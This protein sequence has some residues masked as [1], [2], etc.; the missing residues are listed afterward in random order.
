LKKDLIFS[1]FLCA[2]RFL[3]KKKRIY[4]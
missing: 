4:Y 3:T 2:T 1:L